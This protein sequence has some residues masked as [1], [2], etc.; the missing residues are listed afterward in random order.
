MPRRSYLPRVLLSA[1]VAG[2]SLAVCLNATARAAEHAVYERTVQL[3]RDRYLDR[4]EVDA[5]VAFQE[6][7]EAAEDA[8]PWLIVEPGPASVTLRHGERGVFAVLTLDAD[9]AAALDSLPDALGRIEDAVRAGGPIPDD[10]DLPIELLRGA[11]RALDRHS[12]VLARSRLERFDERIS[13]KLSGVG[14]RIGL[15]AG[16]LVVRDAFVGGPAD[17]GGLRSGDVILRVDGMSTL[18]MTVN[19]AVSRIR[20]PKETQVTLSIRRPGASADDAEFDL[21]LTRD[22]VVIPNVRWELRPSGVGLVTVEHF[23]EQTAGLLSQALRAFESGPVPLKGVVLDLRGNSGGSMIQACRSVDLFVEEGVVL[24]TEG[25][26]GDKV[27]NLLPEYRAHPGEDE[28]PVPVVVLVD[29]KSA[30]ASEILAGALNLLDRAILIGHE[31]HGK[32]TVQKL[33]TVRSGGVDRRARLKLTVARYLLP[34]DIPIEAG[35]GLAPDVRVSAARFTEDGVWMPVDDRP[36]PLSLLWVDERAGWRPTPDAPARRSGVWV[37]LAEDIIAGAASPHRMDLL[38]AAEQSVRAAREAEEQRLVEVFARRGLDWAPAP[39]PGVTP[40]VKVSLRTI[41]PAKAGAPVEVRA[42]VENQGPA[43]LYRTRVH[44]AAGDRALPWHGLVLPVGRLEPGQSLEGVATTAVSASLPDS[45]DLVAVTVVA[46]RRPAAALSSRPMQV[47]GRPLP[48]LAISLRL[49]PQPNGTHRAEI[50]V[51]NRGAENLVDVRARFALPEEAGVELLDRDAF[52]PYLRPGETQRLDLDVRLLD[53]D[54]QPVDLELRLSSGVHGRML[55]LPLQ[56]PTD[57]TPIRRQPPTLS[58]VVPLLVDA[59]PLAVAIEARDEAVV[60]S[61]TAWLDADKVAW[62]EGTGRR[63]S[64]E[65]ALSLSPG[66]HT[67]VVIAEDQDGA[68][69][70]QDWQVRARDPA[71]ED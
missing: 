44:L 58:A 5:L 69:T 21:I 26:D 37:E 66:P 59:G 43:T 38:A 3:I 6:A 11:T 49:A 12:V 32:G 55:H 10:I 4:A 25:P 40:S 52:A 29:R 47:V 9:G 13:G 42:T 19:Q 70:R 31:T 34:D 15:E 63:L 62:R 48:P 71:V 23:S 46:D 24:R 2:A 30:S 41:E 27:D 33:Y 18:G 16:K 20:G 22:E 57:G 50:E 53:P 7:A 56:V 35:Q 1:L 17:L 65:L 60:Q 36:Q 64:L 51:T 54:G 14:A 28:P 68:T 67:L 39:E 45:D 61:V 8:V